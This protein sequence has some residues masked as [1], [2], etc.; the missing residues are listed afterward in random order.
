MDYLQADSSRAQKKLGWKATITAR[1]LAWIMVDADL[2]EIGQPFP[3]RGKQ[4]IEEHFDG[5]H[6][7]ENI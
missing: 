3:G 7:W 4:F 5:W 2:A 1:E 6:T